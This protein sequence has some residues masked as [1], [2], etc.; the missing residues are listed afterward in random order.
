ME[1]RRIIE[2]KNL[3]VKSMLCKGQS[4]RGVVLLYRQPQIVF[5]PF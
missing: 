4:W 5:G 1:P 3:D 2:S